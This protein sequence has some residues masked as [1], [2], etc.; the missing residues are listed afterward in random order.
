MEYHKWMLQNFVEDSVG[1]FRLIGL[2]A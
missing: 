2:T 1:I